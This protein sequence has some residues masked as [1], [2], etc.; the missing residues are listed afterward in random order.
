M[1]EES[2][3]LSTLSRAA[4]FGTPLL[5]ASLGEICAERSGVINLGVEGMMILGAF[6]VAYTTGSPF[7]GILVAAVV[8]GA[9]AL[10]HASVTITLRA[11]QY[12]S[13]LALTM[14]GL[15]LA[16]LLG[17][18]WEGRPLFNA[19]PDITLP[20]LSH[21]PI[22]GPALFTNQSVLTYLGF[23]MAILLWF[24]LTHTRLGIVIRSVGEAPAAVDTLGLPVTLT[25]YSCVVFGGMLAG[26][27]G[28]FLSVSLPTGVD[29]RHHRR[30]GL[31]RPSADDFCRLGRPQSHWCR[32]AIRRTVPP[33][34]SLA[35]VDR[36]R[37]AQAHAVCLHHRR[38]RG[39]GHEQIPAWA[40]CAGGVRAP[41]CP[42]SR[43]DER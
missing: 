19:L 39:H 31:D 29:H 32:A 15:G 1:N 6:A 40:T 41:L 17:R 9:A 22:L 36:A 21:V 25:R 13:G 12:V 5:W 23:L 38:P 11:N 43:L 34:L 20:G 7:L 42:R 18:G 26:V 10:L 3:I 8:G 28:S 37:I 4:A 27:A 35:G 33:V 16:G 24:V 14:F 2:W 30:H